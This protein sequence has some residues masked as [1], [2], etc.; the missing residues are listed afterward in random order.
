MSGRVPVDTSGKGA[1]LGAQEAKIMKYKRDIAKAQKET[2]WDDMND[3]FDS[4]K[5]G[6]G[7]TKAITEKI[8]NFLE[9]LSPV[10]D[11]LQS[12]L[13]VVMAGFTEA[14]MPAVEEFVGWLAD[15]AFLDILRGLGEIL[16]VALIPAFGWLYD[17]LMDLTNDMDPDTLEGFRDS[18]MND[19]I[20]AIETGAN[21]LKEFNRLIIAPLSMLLH[22][23]FDAPMEDLLPQIGVTPGANPEW[24]EALLGTTSK[25]ITINVQG[26]VLDDMTLRELEYRQKTLALFDG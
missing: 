24:M 17:I 10:M 6:V 23:G 7:E 11:V 4:F 19:I 5:E 2:K 8:F 16:Y 25:S 26:S 14:I 15:P 12:G 20:P 9:P 1:K 3:A 22:P 13:T 18:L 21:F